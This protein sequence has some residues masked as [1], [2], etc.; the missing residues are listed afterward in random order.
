[1]Q[2]TDRTV[3]VTGGA[4]GIGQGIAQC[5]AEEG[6]RLLIADWDEEAGNRFCKELQDGGRDAVFIRTNVGEER[7]LDRIVETALAR[8]GRIDVLVNN[9]G[10]H[11]YKPMLDI[12]A[13][14]F[15][16]VIATDLR[17]HWL[18]S[19]KAMP[20]MISSGSGAIVHI[21]SV[22]AWATRPNFSV[23]AAAKGGIV[24]MA[25]AMAL[26]CAPHG[27]RVNTVLPGY[28]I[29]SR[30]QQR[31]NEMPAEEH[32]AFLSKQAYNIPLGRLAL[33]QD[34]GHAVVF[35]ASGKASFITG[36]CLAVDGG[37]TIHLD[38]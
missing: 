20:A 14:D 26:E 10:T 21:S 25:R 15:D 7:D 18:L 16:R 23:Y 22:H 35:L 17:G 19:R 11:L 34:I 3:I 2:S 33:P 28:T 37:E 36:A 4:A 13:D 32:E 6:S 27:I 38:F 30:L 24:S 1:M 29:S 8:W 9:V 5:F 31:L 12:S